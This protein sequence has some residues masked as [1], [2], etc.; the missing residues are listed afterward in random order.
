MVRYCGV[1]TGSLPMSSRAGVS[2]TTQTASPRRNT[3]APAGLAQSK[4]SWTWP[5]TL[6]NLTAT[7]PLAGIGLGRRATKAAAGAGAELVSARA[8][9]L[10]KSSPSALPARKSASSLSA[11]TISTTPPT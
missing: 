1:L 6:E 7:A 11:T 2:N 3:A 8:N 4:L 10:M 5:A 9:R